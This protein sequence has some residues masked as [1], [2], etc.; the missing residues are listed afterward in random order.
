MRI[1]ILGGTRFTG[2]HIVRRLAAGGHDLLVFHRGQTPAR[3]LPP[4]ARELLGDRDRLAAHA[5][6][7][8]AFAPD[9]VLDMVAF[10]KEHA[11]A[12]VE[13]FRG[14]AQRLVVVSSADVYLAFGRI[15]RTEPGPPQALPLTEESELRATNQPNGEAYDKIAVE[16][17]VADVPGLPAT[18]LRYPAV[19]GPGDPLH[20]TFPYLKRMDDGRPHILLGEDHARWRW[21]RGYVENVAEA[22]VLAVENEAAAGRTYNVAEPEAVEEETRVRWI[23]EA[24]RWS[25]EIV[26]LPPERLPEHL[27]SPAD[28]AQHYGVDTYRIRHEL[29]YREVVSRA[30]AYR[31]TIEWQ[32]AHPP[33][34]IDPAQY[35]Y[36]A[37][38]AA[39]E[40]NRDATTRS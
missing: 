26:R 11:E 14:V 39:M 31:R 36:A 12:V 9:V 22:C 8:R 2:P 35:D 20:R 29:G 34:E 13:T 17:A 4:N 5:D 1:A 19:Y 32:R 15:H 30:E 37:E 16:S 24:A 6:D 3:D 38:D 33:A 27:R 7:L 23:A 10:R 28:Y 25:G 40:T 18:I 21:C